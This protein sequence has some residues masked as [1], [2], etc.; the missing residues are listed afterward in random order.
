MYVVEHTAGSA[1]ID[2]MWVGLKARAN[3]QLRPIKHYCNKLKVH[4]IPYMLYHNVLAPAELE[5]HVVF[6]L[7]AISS[8][9]VQE[10]LDYYDRPTSVDYYSSKV[11]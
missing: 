9:S 10:C 7:Q 6:S 8:P 11:C 2:Q 4:A 5:I 1:Q 3:E